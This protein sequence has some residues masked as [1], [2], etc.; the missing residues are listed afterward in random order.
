MSAGDAQRRP[1]HQHVRPR[2]LSGIDRVAQVNV[3]IAAR[4]H[5]AHRGKAR[6]QRGARIHHAGDGLLRVGA[7][8]VR[9]TDRSPDSRSG[10]CARRSSPASPSCRPG[11]SRCRPVA[12]STDAL[13][14]ID[15]IVS[16]TTTMVCAS[17]SLP[18]FTSSTWPARTS[19][20]FAAGGLRSHG[21][22]GHSGS[23]TQQQNNRRFAQE[24]HPVVSR[25]R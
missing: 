17:L 22:G 20:R 10:A 21:Q 23:D 18:V 3:G 15:W 24:A 19:V 4:A 11:R 2:H 25:D 5:V 12:A 16:P 13:G 14:A 7:A 8:S 6:Q 1:A 9:C